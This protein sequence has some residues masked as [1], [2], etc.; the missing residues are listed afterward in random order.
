MQPAP[1][2]DE[3]WFSRAVKLESVALFPL[4][5]S[6]G[7]SPSMALGTMPTRPALLISVTDTH[8]GTG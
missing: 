6:G 7:I 5:V 1:A 3:I 2:T 4:R 8:G